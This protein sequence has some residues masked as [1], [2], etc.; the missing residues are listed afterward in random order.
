MRL[1]LTI[2]AALFAINGP[3]LT[4]AEII[5]SAVPV[6]SIHWNA[7]TWLRLYDEWNE[8]HL[9]ERRGAYAAP[10]GGIGALAG[11]GKPALVGDDRTLTHYEGSV[12]EGIRARLD[13][14]WAGA[15]GLGVD[16]RGASRER[17][18][19]RKGDIQ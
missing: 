9:C 13:R 15:A 6:A 5:F 1:V 4:I 17:N 2:V 16:S 14:S 11:N 10:V 3:V 12:A 7:T 19:R 18:S 8:L